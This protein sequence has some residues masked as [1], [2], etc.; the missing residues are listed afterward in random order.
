[1]NKVNPH[2]RFEYNKYF[3]YFYCDDPSD[4]DIRDEIILEPISCFLEKGFRENDLRLYNRVECFDFE[5]VENLLKQGAKPN[6]YFNGDDDSS[7]L[8][9]IFSEYSYLMVERKL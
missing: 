4:S 5:A 7:A 8:D 3:E 9:R 2:R 6:I 1:V